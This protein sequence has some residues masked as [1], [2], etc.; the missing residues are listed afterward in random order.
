[1]RTAASIISRFFFWGG[2][3]EVV[4]QFISRAHN[5]VCV[6]TLSRIVSVCIEFIISDFPFSRFAPSLY[7]SPVHYTVGELPC[8]YVHRSSVAFSSRSIHE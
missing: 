4:V 5:P 7:R 8:P 2:G 6:K 3:R 1:M